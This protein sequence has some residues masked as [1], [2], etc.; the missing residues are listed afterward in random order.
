MFKT[1]WFM[2]REPFARFKTWTDRAQKCLFCHNILDACDFWKLQ[3]IND[4]PMPQDRSRAINL[5]TYIERGI[6]FGVFE[7]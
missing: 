5:R 3:Q 2:K 7:W 4:S 1:E 6:C